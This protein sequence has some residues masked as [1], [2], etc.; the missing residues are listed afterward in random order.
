MANVQIPMGLVAQTEGVFC[1]VCWSTEMQDEDTVPVVTC[2]LSQMNLEMGRHSDVNT[3]G[4]RQRHDVPSH[5][6]DGKF[7]T[8]V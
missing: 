8:H 7:P 5:H 4:I 2:E 6:G 1:G 3:Q